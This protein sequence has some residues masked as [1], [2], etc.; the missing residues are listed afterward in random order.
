M[1]YPLPAYNDANR[2]VED[3]ISALVKQ[4]FDVDDDARDEDTAIDWCVCAV[5]TRIGDDGAL[6]SK[7]QIHGPLPSVPNYR[8]LGMLSEAQ[9]IIERRAVSE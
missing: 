1:T 8:F 9:R 2:A 7:V 6:Y 5:V 3:A 4:P